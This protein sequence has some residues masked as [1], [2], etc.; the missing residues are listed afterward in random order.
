MRILDLEF[1][2]MAEIALDDDTLQTP[3]C[4]P[5]PARLPITDISQWVERYSLMTVLS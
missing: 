2:E 5:A 1:V 4:P 3:G